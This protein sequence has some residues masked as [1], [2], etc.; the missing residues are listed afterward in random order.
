MK[1]ELYECKA[2]KAENI[3]NLIFM[4]YMVMMKLW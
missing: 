2:K 3:T 1:D 4:L